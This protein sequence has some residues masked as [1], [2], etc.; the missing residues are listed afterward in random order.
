[1]NYIDIQINN[2][3]VT[4]FLSV[5]IIIIFL[6]YITTLIKTI[7]CGKDILSI[8]YTNFVHID[9]YHLVGNL[10]GLYS[11]CK[12]EQSIGSKKFTLLIS[13]LLIFNTIF[14]SFIHKIIPNTKCSIGFSGIIFGVL[15]WEIVS[16][17][18][19]DITAF[20]SIL[21]MIFLP[22]IK[23]SKSSLSGHIVGCIGGIISGLIWSK[24][25]LN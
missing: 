25:N 19:I 2:I 22:S 13:F 10:L 11:L 20:L 4:V 7:P 24:V 16:L 9:F 8:F 1:M 12:V 5:T 18:K 3:P 17:K 6:L 23:N 21:F 15:T 14:E